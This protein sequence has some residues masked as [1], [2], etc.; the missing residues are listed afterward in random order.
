MHPRGIA[1]TFLELV[2]GLWGGFYSYYIHYGNKLG[3]ERKIIR[4]K[5]SFMHTKRFNIVFKRWVQFR[6][7]AIPSLPFFLDINDFKSI[8]IH[9]LKVL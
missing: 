4:K 3:K 5:L 9:S 1:P 2:R 8:D 7:G 6:V